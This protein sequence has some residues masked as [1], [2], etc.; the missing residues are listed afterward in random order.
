MTQPPEQIMKTLRKGL[1]EGQDIFE[2]LSQWMG[3]M[4][5]FVTALEMELVNVRSQVAN[6]Q[7]QI[8]EL[9]GQLR[10]LSR[11]VGEKLQ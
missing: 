6:Q 10:E 9:E 11:D 2:V 5:K 1:G 3:D 8:R 7:H 4:H